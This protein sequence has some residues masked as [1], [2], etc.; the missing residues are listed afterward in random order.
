MHQTY[1]KCRKKQSWHASMLLLPRIKRRL[2]VM[3]GSGLPVARHTSL[4][5]LPSFTVI[6]LDMFTILAGTAGQKTQSKIMQKL[7]SHAV[8]LIASFFA[9]FRV[10]QITRNTH[11]PL[12]TRREDG[13]Q[14]TYPPLM[15]VL[16]ATHFLGAPSFL[17]HHEPLGR[18]LSSTRNPAGVQMIKDT[19]GKWCKLEEASNRSLQT[20]QRSDWTLFGS[21]CHWLK[22]HTAEAH[23]MWS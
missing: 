7:I 11:L 17:E 21:P 15:S 23:V 4:T 13:D 5:L 12:S 8:F 20:K 2:H 14:H 3:L 9:K 16:S 1:A 22:W 19:D 18:E 6:S 10:G